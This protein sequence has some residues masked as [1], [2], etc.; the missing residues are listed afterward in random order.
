MG[1]LL[2]LALVFGFIGS[3]MAT[4]RQ[5]SGLGGF[6]WGFCLGA[7]GLVIIA[8]TPEPKPSVS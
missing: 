5:N 8:M 6:C 3:A 4:S 1:L 7:I 2:I